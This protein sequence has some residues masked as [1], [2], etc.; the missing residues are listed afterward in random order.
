M[1]LGSVTGSFLAG[2]AVTKTGRY[3]FLTLIGSSTATLMCLVIAWVGLGHSLLLDTGATLLLGLAF[4]CQFSPI[5]V[6]IQN[7]VEARDGGIAIACMMFFRLMG[8]AFGVAILSALLLGRLPEHGAAADPAAGGAGLLAG[9]PGRRRH[10]R[11][12][13]GGGAAAEGDPAARAGLAGA[14]AHCAAGTIH[15]TPH[16]RN[17]GSNVRMNRRSILGAA[18]A[19]PILAAP[20]IAQTQNPEIRWR[21]QSAASRSNLDILYFG[22]ET[23][24]QAR[25]GADRQ[26]L[27]DPRLLRRRDRPAA[28][29]AG[30]G[31]ERHHRM[32]PDRRSTTISART[33]RSPSSPRCPSAGITGS[34]A[35]G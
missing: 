26:P 32:R 27:P 19:V 29:G 34:R 18:T 6:T 30:R 12:L 15:Y 10:R 2:Q 22:A 24:Q 16:T 21:L 11:A 23:D 17:L 4:G 28:A 14:A 8:G 31:A 33:R 5:T 35:P 1:T 20:A 13:P 7:A 25:G 9:L 3:R